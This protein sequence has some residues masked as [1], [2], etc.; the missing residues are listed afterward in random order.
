MEKVANSIKKQSC[1]NEFKLRQP[2]GEE[3]EPLS[4]RLSKFSGRPIQA[5]A[6]LQKQAT[7]SAV[8]PKCAV[9]EERQTQEPE[10]DEISVSK[11]AGRLKCFL[12]NWK[13]ITSDRFIL[14]CIEGYKIRF[15][16]KPVQRRNP[17][18]KITS[19]EEV[20]KFQNA[21]EELVSKGAIEE[22]KP[23]LNDFIQTLHFKME[24]IRTAAGLDH[25]GCFM[26]TLDLQDAY[27]LVPIHVS[28]RK[29]LRFKFLGRVYQFTCLPFG[30]NL[31][32]F[33]FTKLLKPVAS[34]LRSR[35]FKSVIYLDDF[36][37]IG[38]NY[39]SCEKNIIETCKLLESLGFLIN[40]RKSCRTPALRCK[41]LGVINH[42]C[43][44]GPSLS[45]I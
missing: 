27:Y 21:I 5:K 30:L 43:E 7:K 15:Y 9:P 28:S 33:I 12:N 36:L 25:P 37:C 18:P 41:F 40:E 17:V 11:V 4:G 35:G 1:K 8:Q 29:Y 45:K 32:P 20:K 6:C 42:L 14:D 24:D 3:T 19:S 23:C 10:P 2:A 39:E 44:V 13:E 16:K 38:E 22:C 31:S 26:G 34:M